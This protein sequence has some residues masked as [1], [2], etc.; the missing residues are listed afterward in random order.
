LATSRDIVS[1]KGHFG[2]KQARCNYAHCELLRDNLVTSSLN[3]LRLIQTTFELQRIVFLECLLSGCN[4]V[5]Q[6]QF[7]QP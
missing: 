1:F 4:W 6:A 2:S 5:N 3:P 7:K